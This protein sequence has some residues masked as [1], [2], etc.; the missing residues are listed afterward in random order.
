M[1]ASVNFPLYPF[2]HDIMAQK[3]NPK[4]PPLPGVGEEGGE[5]GQKAEVTPT[6]ALPHQGGGVLSAIYPSF[7]PSSLTC[8]WVKCVAGQR[9]G[10]EG[11]GRRV[12]K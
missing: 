10:K 8:A 5:G 1:A 2:F 9:Q 4:S 3:I 11:R 7:I 6:P 12:L